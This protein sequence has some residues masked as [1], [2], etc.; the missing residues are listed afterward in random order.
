M[1]KFG[2]EK[3][4]RD[5]YGSINFIS[6]GQITELT[7]FDGGKLWY[8]KMWS[9]LSIYNATTPFQQPNVFRGLGI[10][11]FLYSSFCD[12]YWIKKNISV[13]IT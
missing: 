5:F 6:D 11:R 7:H 10:I 3:R 8:G 13:E 2:D 1:N 12:P 4:E 9:K